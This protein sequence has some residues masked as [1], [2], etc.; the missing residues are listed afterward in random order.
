MSQRLMHAAAAAALLGLSSQ[1]DAT[2]S[3]CMA[4]EQTGEVA[5]GTVTCLTNLDLLAVVPVVVVGKGSAAVQAA[6][7]LDGIRRP[8]IFAGLM[9][10]ASPQAILDQVANIAGHQSRQY[11]IV[12][13]NGDTVTFSGANNAQWAGGVTGTVGDI[14]Y[15]I[16]GNILAGS[17]VVPAIEA[18]VT[19]TPGDMAEKLMAG[20]DAAR[21]QGGDGRCSCSPGF[22]TSCGCPP[23]SFT[24]SGHIGGMIVARVGDSD[25]PVCDANGCADGNYLMRLNVIAGA[26]GP[27][28][29]DLLQQQFDAWRAGLVGR[30]DAMQSAVSFD[31]VI[32][33]PNGVATT[34]MTITLLDWQ[35]LPITAPIS[36]VT[37]LHAGDSAGL[38]SIGAAADQGGGVFDVELTAGTAEGIDRFVVRVNEAARSILLAPNPTFEYFRP[39]DLDGDGCVDTVDFLALLALWG[40]CPGNCLADL[41]G[42]GVVDTVD[43]LAQLANWGC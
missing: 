20:M 41:D 32:I 18:A 26:G 9:N 23:P 21:D 1:A 43:F 17:C 2:W 39:G 22:P 13:T 30:P 27:D 5:V 14:V 8:V 37:V 29:V 25:D 35:G 3:I 40:P 34:T 4:D 24:K 10:G 6:G 28:P 16:Q 42:N 33:A 11:G 15:A 7:D 12:D 38:S 36:S 19:G 31:P